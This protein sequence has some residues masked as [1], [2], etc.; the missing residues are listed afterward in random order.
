MKKKQICAMF[1]KF[2]RC[3]CVGVLRLV[4]LKGGIVLERD[5]E[6]WSAIFFAQRTGFKLNLF[7][8]TVVEKSFVE[9]S[10]MLYH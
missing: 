7:L 3:R 9:K 1:R 8:W 6:Q 4:A 2:Q 10:Q 5:L